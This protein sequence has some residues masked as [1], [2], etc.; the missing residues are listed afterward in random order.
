MIAFNK[1]QSHLGL[2]LKSSES[3]LMKKT[4]SILYPLMIKKKHCKKNN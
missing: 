4:I 2:I 1:L 3:N